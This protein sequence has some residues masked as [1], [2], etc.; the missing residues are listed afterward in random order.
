MSQKK[1]IGRRQFMRYSTGAAVTGFGFPYIIP[2]SVLGR[3]NLFLPSDKITVG[4]VGMGGMGREDME[5]FLAEPDAHVVAVCD[6]DANPVTLRHD[7][8]NCRRT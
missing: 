2:S 7:C 1:G 5:T 6:V 8:G 3:S 4:C